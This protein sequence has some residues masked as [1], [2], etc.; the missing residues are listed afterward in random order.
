MTIGLETGN[1][2]GNFNNSLFCVLN[3]CIFLFA[4]PH[5]VD[6]QAKNKN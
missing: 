2:Y 6:W 1:V 5:I 3:D 4:I